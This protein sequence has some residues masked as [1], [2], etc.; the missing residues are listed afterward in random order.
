[1]H[2][3]ILLLCGL[4]CVFLGLTT[5]TEPGRAYWVMAAVFVSGAFVTDAVNRVEKAVKAK[6]TPPPT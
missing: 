4:G 6:Q 2:A 3:G 1:M 5:Q